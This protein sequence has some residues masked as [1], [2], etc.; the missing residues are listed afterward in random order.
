MQNVSRKN[1]DKQRDN[2]TYKR[3]IVQMCVQKDTWRQTNRHA[4]RQG[5]IQAET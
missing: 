5:D 3:T 2:F 4:G 1:G